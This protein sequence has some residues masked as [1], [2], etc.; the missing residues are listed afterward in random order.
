MLSDHHVIDSQVLEASPGECQGHP[1]T[2]YTFP[3]VSTLRVVLNG[4]FHWL[5][6]MCIKY[7]STVRTFGV[8]M[9]I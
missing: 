7:G 5:F 3:G 8:N 1:G 6:D 2:G 4:M 9:K